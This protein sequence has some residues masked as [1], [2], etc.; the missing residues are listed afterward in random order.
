MKMN[1]F[2]KWLGIVLGSL[3]GLLVIVLAVFFFKGSA[4]LG[5]TYNITPANVSIPTDAASIERGKHFVQAICSDCHTADLSGKTLLEAP[6]AT[7]DSANLTSGQGGAG[8][9]FTD[10][11]WVRALRDGV[12]NKG[13][14]LV[15]MPAQVFWHFSDQDL[16]AVIAY[17]KTLP[18]V[19]H[20]QPDPQINALGRIM[21]GAGMFGADIVPA[22]VI[23]HDQR[24]PVVPEGVTAPYGE[25]LVSVTGCHDC[26]GPELAGGKSKKP[27]AKAAPN[28][29]PGGE[30]SAWTDAQFIN[31]IRTG[32]TPGGHALD[33]DEMPWKF[34][35]N[36]SDDE[37]K[38]I[39]LYLQS[40]PALPTVIP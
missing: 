4:M 17:L 5:R 28:L 36:Y 13:R 33:P 21:I 24:P 39:F 14:A 38:A 6:F 7:V 23:A 27:G 1:V 37:L 16:G 29:T 22:N 10:A 31:T 19:D 15:L 32:T 9:E 3:I 25:Y 30:V 40:R 35:N 11:D 34:F 2:L 26:H 8:S 12:D 20:E 18:P